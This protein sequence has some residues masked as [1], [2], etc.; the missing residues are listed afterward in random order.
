MPRGTLSYG[1]AVAIGIG[2]FIVLAV[3]RERRGRRSR[4]IDAG[5]VDV[6]CKQER[7]APS[8]CRATGTRTIGVPVILI[9]ACGQN[10]S[11]GI[12]AGGKLTGVIVEPTVPTA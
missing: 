3:N 10:A 4:D 8:L 5:R 12:Q 1:E 2:L 11:R 9:Q 7:S 6:R